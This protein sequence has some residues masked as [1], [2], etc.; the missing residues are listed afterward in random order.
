[1]VDRVF[2]SRLFGPVAL[3]S[4]SNQLLCAV[5]AGHRYVIKSLTV[6]N[7]SSTIVTSVR[8]GLGSASTGPTRILRVDVPANTSLYVST[9]LVLHEG[10]ELYG[11]GEATSSAVLTGCGWDLIDDT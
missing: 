4:T 5:P 2:T 6:V 10:E 7:N 1:M 9:L 3:V 8:A 11:T